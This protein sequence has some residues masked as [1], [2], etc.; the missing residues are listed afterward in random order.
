MSLSL[1]KA[2][3]LVQQAKSSKRQ[4]R[5]TIRASVNMVQESEQPHIQQQT[6]NVQCTQCG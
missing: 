2:V 5:E 6:L 4:V 3:E 1:A